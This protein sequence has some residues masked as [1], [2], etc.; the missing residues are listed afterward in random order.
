MKR[1]YVLL[2]AA[3]AACDGGETAPG[4]ALRF[5]YTSPKEIQVTIDCVES[6]AKRNGTYWIERFQL[7]APT[8][9]VASAN[10]RQD[11]VIAVINISPT[12]DG[13]AITVHT[14]RRLHG[15]SNAEKVVSGCVGEVP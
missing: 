3:L 1:P 12:P 7:K 15:Q 10:T 5:D 9:Y 14:P 11:G 4:E 13:S 2:A 6:S 8:G